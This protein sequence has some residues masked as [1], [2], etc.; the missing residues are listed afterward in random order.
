MSKSKRPQAK[1]TVKKRSVNVGQRRKPPQGAPAS[2]Q[3]PQR[4]LGQFK[5]AGE[6]S[7]T[8]RRGR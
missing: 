6:A 3:D 1:A 4:R 2:E 8:G 7:R 5:S